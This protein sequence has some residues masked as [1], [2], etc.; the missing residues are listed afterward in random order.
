MN[1]SQITTILKHAVAP[2]YKFLGVFA[3][4][5]IP[6]VR[7]YPYCYVS[8]TRDSDHEGEH[9]VA[10]ILHSPS[11][12]EFFDSFAL[13]PSAYGFN[14]RASILNHKTL[15]ALS[16]SVCG[17]Y[18]ILYLYYRSH[19]V[20]LTRFLSKFSS[21]LHWNDEQVARVVHTQFGFGKSHSG[22][23]QSCIARCMC[24]HV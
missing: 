24:N 20:S 17:E 16:S 14:I 1:T 23:H 15:Q 8:N 19:G 21:D 18:C 6:R 2:P 22:C 9:W 7:T 4:D 3:R 11:S 12:V 5:K 10:F 13:K